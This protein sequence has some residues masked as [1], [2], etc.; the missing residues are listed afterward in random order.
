MTINE[1]LT[2]GNTSSVDAGVRSRYFADQYSHNRIIRDLKKGLNGL[3]GVNDIASGG[4]NSTAY[5][6]RFPDEPDAFYQLRVKRT[7]LTN[8]FR[9]TIVSDSG[10]ILANNVFIEVDK[11]SNNEL[12]EPYRSW[13]VDMTL[14]KENVSMLAQSQ[15]EI[16]MEK[17]VSI[18][19]VD[20]SAEDGRP[21]VREIDI[22]S[23]LSFRADKRTQKLNYLRFLTK[24][25]I[26]SDDE[27][28]QNLDTQVFELTPTKWKIFK[29]NE[30]G[31]DEILDQGEI[32][33]YESGS[34]R[35]TD[36]IPVSVMYTNKEGILL[37]ESPY[38]TL[39]ELTIEHFQVYS[40]IKNMMFYA[41]TP[42]LAALGVP[43]DFDLQTLASFMII[44][45][46]EVGETLPE[47]KWVQ[48]DSSALEAGQ[49]QLDG[50]ERRIATF[51]IDSNAIRPGTLT[52][53]QAS[54]EGAGTN[55]ALRSFAVVL[56][57]HVRNI[58]ELME[59]YTIGQPKDIKVNVEPE[60][61]SLE[62]DKEMRVIL[63][64][65][66]TGDLS[67]ESVVEAAIQR[68][69]LPP[70]FNKDKNQ[71]Q[72]EKELDELAK[73]EA[74][75]AELDAKLNKSAQASDGNLS[76]NGEGQIDDKPKN[77]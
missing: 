63:E 42:M 14:A 53:T 19:M 17:G 64:M 26:D 49:A 13:T 5:L 50:I 68:K 16:A 21:F 77:T 71:E 56:S 20:Y 40:D 75:K 23:I 58:L 28:G 48:V 72:I 4:G 54:M 10:K 62:T 59:T 65:R 6:P 15:L 43:G 24:V 73:R 27:D 37:A 9:R 41:L 36:E 76:G 44:K 2:S 11:L 39:A 32:I 3:R 25:V 67:S 38:Q 74:E 52:A 34:K 69:L 30:S 46:P 1:N 60:F 33:R 45:V 18:A 47:I 7:Y 35:I 57:D 8:F 70:N 29:S 66:R 31:D 51:S 61:N 22:D 12:P 55:A